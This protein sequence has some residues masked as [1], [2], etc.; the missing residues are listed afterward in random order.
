MR[1]FQCSLVTAIHQKYSPTNTNDSTPGAQ[2]DQWSAFMKPELVGE[3]I[4]VRS[5]VLVDKTHLWSYMRI[6]F[7]AGSEIVSHHG[8]QS[9]FAPQSFDDHRTHIPP[10]F[11]RS[12]MIKASL[13]SCG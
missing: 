3:K 5:R 12:S 6:G 4:S 10:P 11:P 9:R 8:S 1:N 13:S 7:D 2:A